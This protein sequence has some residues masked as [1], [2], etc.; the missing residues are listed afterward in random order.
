VAYTPWWSPIAVIRLE[1]HLTREKPCLT[2]EIEK[3][4]CKNQR[5]IEFVVI[6]VS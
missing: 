6:T 4:D 1:A 5:N 2:L 3:E